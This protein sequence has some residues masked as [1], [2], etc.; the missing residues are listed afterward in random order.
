MSSKGSPLSNRK[1]SVGSPSARRLTRSTPAGSRDLRKRGHKA[2]ENKTAQG[3]GRKKRIKNEDSSPN[4]SVGDNHGSGGSADVDPNSETDCNS[5]EDEKIVEPAT[6]PR[7][8]KNTRVGSNSEEKTQS[9]PLQDALKQNNS[10]DELADRVKKKGRIRPKKES[11]SSGSEDVEDEEVVLKKKVRGKMKKDKNDGEKV[12]VR[13]FERI[14]EDCASSEK[15]P[16]KPAEKSPEKS[17]QTAK[18]PESPKKMCLRCKNPEPMC[19]FLVSYRPYFDKWENPLHTKLSGAICENCEAYFKKC[20]EFDSVKKDLELEKENSLKQKELKFDSFTVKIKNLDKTKL[21]NFDLNFLKEYTEIP[22]KSFCQMSDENKK[23]KEELKEKNNA[24]VKNLEEIK[25]L[26]KEIEQLKAGKNNVSLQN[27]EENKKLKKEIEQLKG[28]TN[29]SVQKSDEAKKISEEWEKSKKEHKLLVDKLKEEIRVLEKQG[30]S[31]QQSEFAKAKAELA[32]TKAELEKLKKEM[33][34]NEMRLN[35]Y[36]RQNNDLKEKI[37]EIEQNEAKKT[38]EIEEKLKQDFCKNEQELKQNIVKLE[39]NLKSV[40]DEKYKID[41]E[42]EKL[43]QEQKSRD[44]NYEKNIDTWERRISEITDENQRVKLENQQIKKEKIE[45]ENKIPS[46]TDADKPLLTNK[47]IEDMKAEMKRIKGANESYLRNKK[48]ISLAFEQYEAEIKALK[49]KV[50]SSK[51]N[52]CDTDETSNRSDELRKENRALSN[53]IEEL[54]ESELDLRKTK[55]R[56]LEEIENLKDSLKSKDDLIKKLE[57]S[58]NFATD[59]ERKIK[60][61]ATEVENL[62]TEK[63]TLINENNKKSVLQEKQLK[64]EKEKSQK[65][66]QN[67]AESFQKDIKE[68]N[69]AKK[70]VEEKMNQIS[71]EKAK[72][73][74]ELESASEFQ[75]KRMDTMHTKLD[76]LLKYINETLKDLGLSVANESNKKDDILIKLQELKMKF[77]E[78]SKVQ[79]KNETAKVELQ[80][81]LKNAKKDLQSARKEL[82]EIFASA[83]EFFEKNGFTKPIK[84]KENDDVLTACDNHNVLVETLMDTISGQMKNKSDL[85]ITMSALEAQLKQEK[86]KYLDASNKNTQTLGSIQ[87]TYEYD[88]GQLQ[89]ELE[90]VTEDLNK[91]RAANSAQAAQLCK[92]CSSLQEEK[93]ELQRE[94]ETMLQEKNTLQITLDT[95]TKIVKRPIMVEHGSQTEDEVVQIPSQSSEVPQRVQQLQHHPQLSQSPG[96]HPVHQQP[97]KQVSS[98]PQSTMTSMSAQQSI[99]SSHNQGAEVRIP[100][101][102][103]QQLQRPAPPAYRNIA[104]RGR[105]HGLQNQPRMAPVQQHVQMVQQARAMGPRANYAVGPQVMG[106]QANMVVSSQIQ[107]AQVRIP[108]PPGAAAATAAAAI[109]TGHRTGGVQVRNPNELMASPPTLPSLIEWFQSRVKKYTKKEHDFMKE[110][111]STWKTDLAE[112]NKDD[113]TFGELFDELSS[114]DSYKA[115]QNDA[116]VK[117]LLRMG[118]NQVYYEKWSIMPDYEA[119]KEQFRLRRQAPIGT[120][121]HMPANMQ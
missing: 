114:D 88:K 105:G 107:Q 76:D 5:A 68:L 117:E 37:K 28:K 41:Q 13:R 74:S 60:A 82:Q 3:P 95:I 26:K 30:S 7:K 46:K 56:H 1:A 99:P 52:R 44:M 86:E 63:K 38:Q 64:E 34:Q 45:L 120:V 96:R 50:E 33:E 91:V 25:K 100:V 102:H 80:I 51:E 115:Y 4:E 90:R 94:K 32:K 18:L 69:D 111:V 87:K 39:A 42:N 6:S 11:E 47:E 20:L 2:A 16:L 83:L 75:K 23:L 71:Q 35:A 93:E 59:Q 81:E 55:T 8:K 89:K 9:M 118:L 121:H 98:R 103:Q 10:E 101:Q 17:T 104:P 40:S 77:H 31:E 58:N 36:S 61:L 109:A 92:N 62:G 112:A 110:Q 24:D 48:R 66:L 116:K 12:K 65:S 67:Q 113:F 119:F 106:T 97:Q 22:P 72:I 57:A 70:A 85:E 108:N 21:S 49:S 84:C 19:D 27:L 43:L 29:I 79:N 73:Q 78:L 54:Q 53:E 14:S 15:S